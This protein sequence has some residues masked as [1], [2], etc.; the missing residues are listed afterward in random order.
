M[1]SLTPE[2]EYRVGARII[3]GSHVEKLEQIDSAIQELLEIKRLECADERPNMRFL[4]VPQ[5]S[6]G[7]VMFIVLVALLVLLAWVLGVHPVHAL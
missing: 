4:A 1:K 2:Q 7:G 6:H 3:S 5:R